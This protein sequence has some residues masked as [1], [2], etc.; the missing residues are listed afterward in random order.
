MRR[1]PLKTGLK[2]DCGLELSKS[3]YRSDFDKNFGIMFQKSLK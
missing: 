2:G 3:F 1:A